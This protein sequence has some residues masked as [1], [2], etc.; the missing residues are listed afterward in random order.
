MRLQFVFGFLWFF[1]AMITHSQAQ[2]IGSKT[3]STGQVWQIR[4][5]TDFS[6][7]PLWHGFSESYRGERYLGDQNWEWSETDTSF[8]EGF[9]PNNWAYN[10]RLGTQLN[11]V[12]DL[13]VGVNYSAYIYRR[14]QAIEGGGTAIST[15]PF[16]ALN[17]S[18]SYPYIL[19]FAPKVELL[20]TV[21]FGRYQGDGYSDYEG[22]GEEWSFE[23]R[24][25]IGLRLKKHPQQFRFWAAYS[26][27][28]YNES[29][30]SWVYPD[31]MREISTLWQ[32]LNVGV[33][34]VWHIRI[35]EDR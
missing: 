7:I 8:S 22:L 30:Q 9:V 31:R 24:M 11:L 34:L 16:F 12:K 17:A 13:Y 35:E 3:D 27:M 28:W 23:G 14:F 2:I 32:F 5:V 1:A 33:G 29:Q 20:P 6:P 26:R 19:P 4:F 10:I 18:L 21:S 15:I 25:G